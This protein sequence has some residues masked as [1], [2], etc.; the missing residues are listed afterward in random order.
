MVGLHNTVSFNELLTLSATTTYTLPGSLS[1]NGSVTAACQ[2]TVDVF[3]FG[4]FRPDAADGNLITFTKFADNSFSTTVWTLNI[5]CGHHIPVRMI[6]D[7]FGHLWVL[8][9]ERAQATF[10]ATATNLFIDAGTGTSKSKYSHLYR[11]NA[12]SL[13]TDP[14]VDIS[15]PLPNYVFKDMEV[16]GDS[17]YLFGE[18]IGDPRSSVSNILTPVVYK[19]GFGEVFSG[20]NTTASMQ[21]SYA[22]NAGHKILF[23][24]KEDNPVDT[25]LQPVNVYAIYP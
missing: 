13:D 14:Y 16:L 7:P 1:A 22:F 21:M 4:Y 3:A 2:C 6:V 23:S 24:V 25:T 20:H 5:P 17:I 11:Y 19:V 15:I 8:A 9:T 12:G 10:S 18:H